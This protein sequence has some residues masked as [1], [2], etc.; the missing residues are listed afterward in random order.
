M[1]SVD[2][3]C[4]SVLFRQFGFISMPFLALVAFLL[5]I[6]FL[7]LPRRDAADAGTSWWRR[8]C[9]SARPPDRHLRIGPRD[10]HGATRVPHGPN[11]MDLRPLFP[12]APVGAPRYRGVDDSTNG[13][14]RRTGGGGA[15]GW[16]GPGRLCPGHRP[17]GS[18]RGASDGQPQRPPSTRSS[19]PRLPRWG[20][21]AGPRA[22]S[23]WSTR[24]GRPAATP[25]H[26]SS[27]CWCHR[28]SRQDPT[29]SSTTSPTPTIGCWQRPTSRRA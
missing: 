12:K 10:R 25:R 8:A 2:E 11:G 5:V 15:P 22:G 16:A 24:I 9:R 7:L 27:R 23:P 14:D 18:G 29:V 21:A 20:S 4:S 13:V 17:R 28:S 26:G 3:P 19:R 6:A 1:C